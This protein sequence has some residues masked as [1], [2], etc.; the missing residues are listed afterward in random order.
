MEIKKIGI[1]G[2]TGKMGQY[3]ARF[4]EERKFEVYISGKNT[5]LTNIDLA[6]KV[7]LL[8]FSVPIDQTIKIIDSVKNYIQKNTLVFDLTSIKI[9][10]V[11][12]MLKSKA[13]EVVGGHPMFGPT[14]D[15]FGQVFVLTPGRGKKGLNFLKNIFEKAGANIKILEPK[16]HDEL[17][18]VIQGLTHFT[19]IVLAKTLSKTNI[20]IDE[21]LE[22]QSPAYRLKLIMIG[23]ILA[24]SSRLY[25]NIQIENPLNLQT[26]KILEKETK[27]LIEII[28]SKNLSSFEKYFDDGAKYFDDFTDIAMQESDLIIK[29]IFQQKFLK[30]DIEIF[31]NLE[32]NSSKNIS[33]K[34]CI[35]KNSNSVAILGPKNTYSDFACE[36]I[37]GPSHPKQYHRTIS[38]VFQAVSEKKCNMGVVPVENNL[39]GSINETYDDLWDFDDIEI[40]QELDLPLQN[41]LV[42]L[43]NTPVSKIKKVFSHASPLRQCS[44][45]LQKYPNIEKIAVSSTAEAVQLLDKNSAAIIPYKAAKKISLK[46]L[47]ENIANSDNNFTRFYL[48]KK[49]KNEYLKKQDN[50]K[51]TIISFQLKDDK[52]SGALFEV[53]DYFYKQ[54]INLLKIQ[55]KPVG[56]EGCIAFFLDLDG[57]ITKSQITDLQKKVKVLKIFGKTKN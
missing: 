35:N 53:L 4:F 9:P 44:N 37:F 41:T 7:D 11:E 19:D 40:I 57:N 54:N 39:A 8:I 55:S 46:I 20:K 24:Q 50:I 27:K 30:K 28:K 36:K 48:I 38:E 18:T 26:L 32:K 47:V 25:G 12:I 10:I 3:F 6:K 49:R 15:I 52:K 29:K 56:T 14:T 34:K 17:M 21:F 42:G 43:T 33:C 51:R 13:K 5:K 45:F 1:I 22:Y 2:G 16:K 31:K 23:R